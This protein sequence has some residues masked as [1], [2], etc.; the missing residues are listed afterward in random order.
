MKLKLVP[1][2]KKVT[3]EE[4]Y[5]VGGI[6]I[7]DDSPFFECFSA[8]NGKEI[9]Y[10]VDKSLMREAYRLTVSDKITV[11]FSC[12]EGRLHAEATLYKLRKQFGESI[13]RL[14][15]YDYPTVERRGVQLCFGQFNV[16]W[17]KERMTKLLFDFAL[18]G[19][20]EIYLYLEWN[21]YLDEYP[22]L[23]QKGINEREM[24][25]FVLM[26]EKYC[27]AVIPQVNLL[28]HS[29][30]ILGLERMREYKEGNST[31]CPSSQKTFDFV[32]GLLEKICD[33]FPAYII[34][35]GGDEVSSYGVCNQCKSKRE[36]SGSLGIFLEYFGK[37]NEF[38]KAKGRKMG[39]W[40]DQLLFLQKDSRFW[41][42]TDQEM[43]FC[44]QNLRLLQSMRDNLV[45]YN[46]WYEGEYDE[47]CDFF[48]SLG[49]EYIVC[50]STNGYVSIGADLKQTNNL[51]N[52][53]SYAE[54]NGCVGELTSDWQ[55][56]N[57][58]MAEHVMFLFAAGA[59]FGWC[60]TANGF[61][62]NQTEEDFLQSYAFLQYGKGK[63]LIDYLRF[64]GDADGP[65]LSLLPDRCRGAALRNE[66]FFQLNPLAVYVLWGQEIDI[67]SFGKA[68]E[69]A[70]ELY[71]KCGEIDFFELPILACEFLYNKLR[72]FT[73]AFCYY[74]EASLAQY[75][76]NE[77][78]TAKLLLCETELKEF[79]K[80]FDA[81]YE[82]A[83]R[84]YP[85]TGN[86]FAAEQ[87]VLE[88]KKNVEKLINF[89]SSLNDGR[90]ALPSVEN[91]SGYFFT[92]KI[93]ELFGLSGFEWQLD[94]CF[95]TSGNYK[96]SYFCKRIK[97]N[98][99]RED[100]NE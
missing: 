10:V 43:Q 37:I 34:H 85:K 32:F 92:P 25:E 38:L 87:R 17:H 13:P 76:N 88:Q 70:K 24:R 53:Y 57:G 14:K 97:I 31:F 66:L 39:L 49:L 3:I 15:I 9:E 74:H 44:N 79:L 56:I 36:Q 89:I 23:P 86:D 33:I 7:A 51:Y 40:S 95:S 72:R 4:G 68:I 48:R 63:E 83:M 18:M 96:N 73:K 75:V 91:I 65:M 46:W 67:V 80:D 61:C 21:F 84:E 30:M 29:G 59:A 41:K 54:H 1:Y 47:S 60:G 94:G 81:P 58:F 52:F 8:E 6:K 90:R 2:P 64:V 42:N 11:T 69:K 20:N 98:E 19:I 100:Y 5:Y 22:F 45:V 26:A 99:L 12:A 35:V 55:N 62:K 16:C 78:F 93:E 77:Q 71:K 28:G 50:G 27:I 82:Y